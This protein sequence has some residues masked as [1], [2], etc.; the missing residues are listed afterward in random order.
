[1]KLFKTP[2]EVCKTFF[3]SFETFGEQLMNSEDVVFFLMLCRRRGQKPV[4]FI[5]ILDENFENYFKKDSLWQ[6]E[7]IEFVVDRDPERVCILHGPV[8]A[9]FSNVLNEPVSHILDSINSF[10]EDKLLNLNMISF[11]D[12]DDF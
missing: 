1:M 3:N 5:P 11:D 4:N 6:S 7:N 2:I 12:L 8:A 9:S 10:H